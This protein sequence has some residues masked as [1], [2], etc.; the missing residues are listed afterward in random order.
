M[1]EDV[2]ELSCL[3]EPA[4]SRRSSPFTGSTSSQRSRC[5]P[6]ARDTF[7]HEDVDDTETTTLTRGDHAFGKMQG[8][9]FSPTDQ[10]LNPWPEVC[11]MIKHKSSRGL[12][13]VTHS[14]CK[15]KRPSPSH[16]LLRG[17]TRCDHEHLRGSRDR[18]SGGHQT[19]SKSGSSIRPETCEHARSW[20]HVGPP[21]L[22]RFK[23]RCELVK[24]SCIVNSIQNKKS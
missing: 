1:G 11:G 23:Q 6:D 17:L 15:S 3:R 19:D 2:S 13:G 14:K 5:N 20:T 16:S 4:R 9:S 7:A 22:S 12:R 24:R 10:P 18:T 8:A 21:V